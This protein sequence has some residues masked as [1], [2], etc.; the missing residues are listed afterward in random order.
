MFCLVFNNRLC[1]WAQKLDFDVKLNNF[2][3]N[4][5]EA[6]TCMFHHLRGCLKTLQF[7]N[8]NT[9]T[10]PRSTNP[11][12]LLL[13]LFV[14]VLFHV[15]SFWPEIILALLRSTFL[16]KNQKWISLSVKMHSVGL[17]I[18]RQGV[19]EGLEWCRCWYPRLMLALCK[20]CS[21]FPNLYKF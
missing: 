8:Q 6:A 10:R 1:A 18:L 7:T 11:G 9:S 14:F 5:H 13:F 2:R 17:A 16:N 12:F 20:I 21:L 15:V 3:L 4:L 19:R